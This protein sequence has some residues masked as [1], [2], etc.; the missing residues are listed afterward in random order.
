MAVIRYHYV[1]G[2]CRPPPDE[3]PSP[4]MQTSLPRMQTPLPRMQTPLDVDS[5]GG[6][7]SGGTPPEA[8]P[9]EV[10]PYPLLHEQND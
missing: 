1:G 7:P 3:D 4:Q 6:R 10:D 5:P 8:D 9:L 2:V